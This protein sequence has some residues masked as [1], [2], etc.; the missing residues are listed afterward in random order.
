MNK[1]VNTTIKNRFLL[2]T[3]PIMGYLVGKFS[4]YE[5]FSFD[6]TPAY[7]VSSLAVAASISFA[8]VFIEKFLQ[9]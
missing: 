5:F 4:P 3:L 2:L 6:L 9:K 8:I 1:G 7:I